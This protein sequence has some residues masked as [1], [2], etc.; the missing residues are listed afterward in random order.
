MSGHSKWAT[1]KYRKGAQDKAR[2]K[3]FA[4]LIRQ[5]E[6]AAREGGT[7]MEVNATL[8]TMYEKARD[9][10]VPLDTIERAIKRGSGE[11]EGVNYEVVTYEGY[12][13][14][15]VAVVVEC[16]TSNRN[17]TAADVRNIFS[18]NGG[19]IA[20]P[21]SV[22]WQFDR[23]GILRVDGKVPEE[24]L[25]SVAVDAGA[26]DISNQQDHWLITCSAKELPA[27]KAALE[28]AGIK[29]I[30]AELDML[31]TTEVKVDQEVE[32]R[33]VL[34]VLDALDDHEDVQNVYSNFDIPDE[35]LEKITSEDS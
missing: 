1:T 17:R 30:A 10:S 21:G 18:R 15:G 14:D 31:A 4:K 29:V 23:K 24:D 12:A 9:A 33:K 13:A 8:R 16:M 3:L 6:V 28:A 32:A 5:L 34:R 19:S 27:C 7:D 26:E 35:I 11:L 2:A 22:L 20:S 25:L